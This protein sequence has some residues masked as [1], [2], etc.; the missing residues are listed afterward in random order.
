ME[1][2][3]SGYTDSMIRLMDQLGRL[4]GIGAKSAERLAYHILRMP[5]GEAQTLAQSIRDVAEKVGACSTCHNLSETDPCSICSDASRRQDVICV[6]EQPKDLMAIER[7]G[8]H[9]GLYHVLRGHVAPLEGV[10]PEDLTI[11]P[12][13]ARVKTGGIGEVILALNPTMEGDTT[14]HLLVSRLSGLGAKVTQ[15]ARGVP[16]GSQLEY[17]SQTILSDALAG[18]R[19]MA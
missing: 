19:Q 13:V 15:I 17:A 18:R 5:K 12:L 8:Q 6:V 11:E 9:R 14:A 4:P 10:G 1:W 16:S 2:R 3:V 7:T